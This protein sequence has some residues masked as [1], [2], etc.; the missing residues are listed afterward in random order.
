[1]THIHKLF[2]L[3]IVIFLTSC[4]VNRVAANWDPSGSITDIKT[5]YVIKL[6]PDG[7]GINKLISD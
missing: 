6:G 7:R 5:F 4:S 2:F 3:L 1:M